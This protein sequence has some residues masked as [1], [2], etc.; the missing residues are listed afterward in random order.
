MT[1]NPFYL[2]LA[3]LL[4][5]T[6]LI[7]IPILDF[8]QLPAPPIP[9]NHPIRELDQHMV[10]V[11]GFWYPLNKN[12]GVL[13]PQPNLRSCCIGSHDKIYKQIV[14]K[15]TACHFSTNQIATLE[16]VFQIKPEYD[17][18]NNLT[19]LYLLIRKNN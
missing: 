17:E 19:Q 13:A 2:A 16:G 7:G 18:Q 8:H 4:Y 3:S 15:D 14:V 10:T 9:E 1:K 11:R 5:F 12:D 6:S